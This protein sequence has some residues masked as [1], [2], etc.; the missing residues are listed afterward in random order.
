MAAGRKLVDKQLLRALVPP[1]AL[2][3]ENFE[4]LARKAFREEIAAGRIRHA[5]KSTMLSDRDLLVN[6]EGTIV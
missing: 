6:S 1:S 4:E 2:N 3:A 5:L